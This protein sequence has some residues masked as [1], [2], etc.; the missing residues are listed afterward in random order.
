MNWELLKP[1]IAGQIRHVLTGFAGA[2]V[3]VGAL[4]SDQAGSFVTI[5]AGIV[6]YGIGAVWSVVQKKGVNGIVADLENQ[7][8]RMSNKNTVLQTGNTK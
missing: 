3:S 6:L 8:G 2:L 5:G 7:V 4:Q 1:F